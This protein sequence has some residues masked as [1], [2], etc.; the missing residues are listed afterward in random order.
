MIDTQ[1]HVAIRSYKRAGLVDTLKL[2]PFAWVWVPESQE[3]DYR[4]HY[5][6]RVRTIPDAADGNC[7]KKSNAILDRSPCPWTL[8]VD[9]DVRMLRYFEGGKTI[10]MTPEHILAMICH[11]FELARDLGVRLWGVAQAQDSMFYATQRPF[12]LTSPILG[13]FGGHLEPELRYDP[14]S[15]TKEDYD[16]FLQNILKYRRCLR[17]NKYH[18]IHAHGKGK[19]GGLSGVRSLDYEHASIA[20]MRAKWG[21]IFRPGSTRGG[22][23][24]TGKNILDSQVRVPIPGC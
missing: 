14:L 4:Q 6:D 8:I 20:Y 9:D 3:A 1:I 17:A 22:K 24:A 19:P 11:H 23:S 10:E 15:G 21:A 2:M 16:F 7:P 5:G 13:P 12:N 18:Y